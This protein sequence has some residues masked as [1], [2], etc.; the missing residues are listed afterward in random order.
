MDRP[1][2]EGAPAEASAA[3]A[4]RGLLNVR[5]LAAWLRTKERKVYDL[6][7]RNEIPHTRVGACAGL[8]PPSKLDSPCGAGRPRAAEGSGL[9]EEL[10]ERTRPDEGR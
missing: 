4:P 5:E 1:P 10:R 7:A 2:G 6:V 9:R 8:P 3:G